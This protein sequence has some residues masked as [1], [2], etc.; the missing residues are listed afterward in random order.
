M[1]IDFRK[2]QKLFV[3]KIEKEASI[4]LKAHE[5]KFQIEPNFNF[6]KNSITMRILVFGRVFGHGYTDDNGTE[7]E[8]LRDCFSRLH[9]YDA[10][11]SG[12][13]I[14]SLKRED[15]EDS[16]QY[17]IEKI[18]EVLLK[19]DSP[20]NFDIYIDDVYTETAFDADGFP[21]Y[22]VSVGFKGK[23]Y[24]YTLDKN[25]YTFKLYDII[26]NLLNLDK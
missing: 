10:D 9:D 15:L 5:V 26:L 8:F 2:L 23:N 4:K 14:R 22:Y 21:E 18:K 6:P 1:K 20:N 25:N 3:E 16:Y 24:T 19:Y 7:E 12:R 11:E 13:H 17:Q